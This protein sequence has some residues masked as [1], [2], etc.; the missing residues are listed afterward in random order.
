MYTYNYKDYD[1]DEGI[2]GLADCLLDILVPTES[3]KGV[4]KAEEKEDDYIISMLAPSLEKEDIKVSYKKENSKNY[5]TVEFTKETDF[6]IKG[7]KV[8]LVKDYLDF[9]KLR[10]GLS[11]GVLTITIPKDTSKVQSGEVKVE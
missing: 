10:A 1:F 7:S 3:Y 2:S 5:V 6:T 9:S 11:K 8:F 4:Y